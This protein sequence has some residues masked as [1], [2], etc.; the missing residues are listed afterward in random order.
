MIHFDRLQ[1]AMDDPQV[2]LLLV[3]A[4]LAVS[5]Q[6]NRAIPVLSITLCCH[7]AASKSVSVTVPWNCTYLA[8]CFLPPESQFPALRL[9]DQCVLV[10]LRH[11]EVAIGALSS[12]E[13]A[14]V[15]SDLYYHINNSP[16]AS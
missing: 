2:Y 1:L 7:C 14:T 3:H 10:S 6:N 13:H 5:F 9:T 12:I 16:S 11:G 8:Y 4:P 15:H